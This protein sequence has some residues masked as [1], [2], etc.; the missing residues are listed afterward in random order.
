MKFDR[1]KILPFPLRA[2][3]LCITMPVALSACSLGPYV[4]GLLSPYRYEIQQGNFIT[5]EMA[6]QLKAGMTRDQVR[7]VLGT[8]LITDAFHGNR[9]DYVF[10]LQRAN[11]KIEFSRYTV[12]F[13]NNLLDQFG[14]SELP[15]ERDNVALSNKQAPDSK[16]GIDDNNGALRGTATAPEL[17]VDDPGTAPMIPVPA[18]PAIALTEPL[19]PVQSPPLIQQSAEQLVEEQILSVVDAWAAAWSAKDADKYLSFYAPDHA[20]GMKTRTVWE[21][22]RRQRLAAP[23]TLQVEIIK[24]LIRVLSD[25]RAVVQFEQRYRSNLIDERGRKTLDMVKTGGGW[26]IVNETFIV[27]KR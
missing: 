7:F 14:G 22:F 19:L 23:S 13:K 8:P 4:P 27:S 10:R 11:G 20:H 12:T 15:T 3:L 18:T 26:Q 16:R 1:Q 5:Q 21:S 2:A 24:P 6:A 17:P 9:W 25:T